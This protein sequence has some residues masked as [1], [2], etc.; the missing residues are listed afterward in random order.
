MSAKVWQSCAAGVGGMNCILI[1]LDG[2]LLLGGM[3]QF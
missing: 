1:G 3:F 2:F